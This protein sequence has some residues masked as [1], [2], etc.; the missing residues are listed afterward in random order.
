MTAFSYDE[1]DEYLRGGGHHDAVGMSAVDGL[2]AALVAGPAFVHPDE[3][4]PLIF[5]GRRPRMRK[6]SPQ[7]RAVQAIFHRYN[8]VSTTLAERP[9]DYCPI[10]MIDDDDNI[11]ATP[12]AGGFILGIALRRQDWTTSILLTPHRHLLVPI[13]VTHPVGGELLP[14]L[15]SAE[16]MQ[17]RAIAWQQIPGAV[18]EVRRVCNPHRAAQAAVGPVPRRLRHARR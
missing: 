12:W 10:F 1:L 11:V 2:I 4:L 14:E 16:Q 13:L 5:N 3:W 7:H 17:Q 6:G 15:R 18:A 9:Q 8:E